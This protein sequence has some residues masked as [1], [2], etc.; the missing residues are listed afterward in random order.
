MRLPSEQLAMMLAWLRRRS[1]FDC[2]FGNYGLTRS[3]VHLQS[4]LVV[5]QFH[6]K[7]SGLK[8]SEDNA[9]NEQHR[10]EETIQVY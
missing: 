3:L 9:P 5:R 4:D 10:S 2:L 1:S 8:T 6:P 7:R